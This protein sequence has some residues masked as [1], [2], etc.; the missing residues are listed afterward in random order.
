MIKPLI[1]TAI[2][3]CLS[4]CA[5]RTPT[6]DGG[7]LIAGGWKIAAKTRPDGTLDAAMITPPAS[8]QPANPADYTVIAGP[9]HTGN[10]SV[11]IIRNAAP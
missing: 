11:R 10:W 3:L 6:G 8:M 7:A 5:Y 9:D 2:C 1:A 4:G